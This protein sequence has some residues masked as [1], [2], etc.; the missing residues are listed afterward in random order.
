[1]KLLF[2]TGNAGKLRELRALA[3]S[4]VEV[5]S[6]A[7]FPGLEEPVEDGTTFEANAIK[8]AVWYSKAT[9]LAALAD[10]SGLCVDALG[11]RPGVMSARYAPGP[12]DARVA[13]LLGELARVPPEQRGAAFVCA[14]CLAVPGKVPLVEVGEC[15]GRIAAKPAGANGFGYDPVFFVTQLGRTMAELTPEEKGRVSHRGAALRKMRQHLEK[16]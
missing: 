10:D 3:G 5:V 12:D 13:R 1:V 8:K 7:E 15:R 4:L 6:L 2:A 9:G 11:G 14:L 16:L